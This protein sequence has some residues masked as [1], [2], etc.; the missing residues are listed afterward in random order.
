[1]LY[2]RQVVYAW[3]GPELTV[4][5][6]RVQG[7]VQHGA[8]PGPLC[9]CQCCAVDWD[10]SAGLVLP[11]LF[12]CC[13]VMF[14]VAVCRRL[15][16]ICPLSP[17]TTTQLSSPTARHLRAGKFGT[18]S[19]CC[20]RGGCLSTTRACTHMCAYIAELHVCVRVPCLLICSCTLRERGC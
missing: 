9:C 14:D 18:F 11:V 12:A 20:P 3:G 6:V 4:R 16:K 19:P 5:P 1:M 15:Q 10:H 2:K 17:P 7:G 8:P 13:C